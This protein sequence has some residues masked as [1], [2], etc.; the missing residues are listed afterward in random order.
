MRCVIT[1]SDSRG[2]SLVLRE[3]VVDPTSRTVF[4][5]SLAGDQA[6]MP[7]GDPTFRDLGVP[8]DHIR[9]ST[10]YF[11][12]GT[13]RDMHWTPTVDFDMVVEGSIELLLDTG[14]VLL[15]QGD[16]AVVAGVRHGWR[17]GD[18]GCL[19]ALVLHGQKETSA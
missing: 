8:P 5:A 14:P 16:S 18:N 13:V 15:E 1:G 11:A 3:E 17:A 9:W 12:P 2:Q 4:W 10:I 7:V 6:A 19:L